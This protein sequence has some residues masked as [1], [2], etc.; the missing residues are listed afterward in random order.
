MKFTVNLSW[1]LQVECIHHGEPS[2]VNPAA[3]SLTLTSSLVLH[4][5]PLRILRVLSF[6]PGIADTHQAQLNAMEGIRPGYWILSQSLF[7]FVV[8]D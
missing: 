1:V 5:W 2:A 3:H 4:C 7:D 8:L 6:I